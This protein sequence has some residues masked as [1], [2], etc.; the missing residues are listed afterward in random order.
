MP[1]FILRQAQ[2]L[3]PFTVI[4][5]DKKTAAIQLSPEEITVI[6]KTDKVQVDILPWL[7]ARGISE[8][9]AKNFAAAIPEFQKVSKEIFG[10]EPSYFNLGLCYAREEKYALAQ[11]AF[12]NAAKYNPYNLFTQKFLADV[13]LLLKKDSDAEKKLKEIIERDMQNT[14]AHL[15]SGLL[16]LKKNNLSLAAD[17]LIFVR[18]LDAEDAISRLNLAGL[19]LQKEDSLK[20]Q[21]YLSEAEKKGLEEDKLNA[22][23]YLLKSYLC[24][25]TNETREAQIAISMAQALAPDWKALKEPAPCLAE[26]QSE[27]AQFQ[28]EIAAK[29]DFLTAA[30]L[31]YQQSEISQR[32]AER[33]SKGN[34]LAA[35]G[36]TT[37]A[38]KPA[39]KKPINLT[40]ELNQT[41]EVYARRPATS[42]PINGLNAVTNLK[43]EGNEKGIYLKTE[44]EAFRNHWDN[45][46][47]DY[48]KVN[49]KDNKNDEIDGGK[50]SAK[51]FPD[52]VSHPSIEQGLRW[53]HRFQQP[54]QAKVSAELPENIN[55]FSGQNI[56]SLSKIYSDKYVDRRMFKTAEI[57]VLCGR[58][59]D[60]INI[61]RE[62]LKNDQTY[63]TSGQFEQ[64]V[65]AFHFMAKP[66]DISELGLSYSRVKD[67]ELSATASATTYPIESE[68]L[69]ID[70][71][72]ELLDGK[73]KADGEVGWGNYDINLLA[74][75]KNKLDRAFTYTLDYKP[76]SLWEF[77]YD[78]KRIG[79]NYE[80]EGAYQTEDKITHTLTS[81]FSQSK[82]T[83]WSIRSI[84][85]KY[86]P[87]HT[88]L[89]KSSDASRTYYRTFQPKVSL[90]LPQ[91][92]KLSFDYKWYYERDTCN[93][94]RYK[95][96]TLVTDLEYEYK[97]IKT[98]IKPSYTFERKDD[99]V[100]SP[101]DEKKKELG[102]SIEN[103]SIKNLVWKYSWDR[104]IKNYV[105]ATT[106]SYVNM[107][108]STEI[109][110]AFIPSRLESTFKASMDDK[111]QTDTNN[112]ALATIDFSTDFTSKDGNTKLTLEYERKNN[113]YEPWL[114]SS[115]YRQNYVKFKLTQKF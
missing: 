52:L 18:N 79:K 49:I 6:D 44:A 76:N 108:Y 60:P 77:I 12:Q 80:V 36:I 82:N 81:K 27:A 19:F 103:K 74:D 26:A 69:G 63:E 106:K 35:E 4:S 10:H 2:K 87:A 33:I 111:T 104:E 25:K 37:S 66:T 89:H 40:G 101:T 85:L 32:I 90:N 20:A 71:K 29:K 45:I 65:N 9:Q 43:L 109:K 3:G 92:A 59:K 47:L 21:E 50:F 73:L 15:K 88:N 5:V 113:V 93:C 75:D 86:E 53:W 39:A 1:A 83:P 62:K 30:P 57:T 102:V 13:S 54:D 110:Y 100:T 105:G 64:W 97:P 14:D 84:D 67:D 24:E 56:P 46:Q 31:E 72:I 114:D 112:I 34:E 78:G 11:K 70:G 94:T 23:Y 91:E 48:Y 42:S 17:E 98:T 28:I 55:D 115:A 107:K 16:A 96:N 38:Q 7:F 58:S 41:L 22:W 51:N 99:L 61:G 8:Y 68:A 95:T